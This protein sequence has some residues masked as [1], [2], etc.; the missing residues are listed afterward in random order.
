MI[1]RNVLK[2]KR[3]KNHLIEIEQT[4]PIYFLTIS[5]Q[6]VVYQRVFIDYNDALICLKKAYN[7]IEH[8]IPL[9]ALDE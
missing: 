5:T 1:E 8:N 6:V 9:E 4:G 7:Y 3:I 2:Q